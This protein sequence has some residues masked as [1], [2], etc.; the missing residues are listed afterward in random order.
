LASGFACYLGGAIYSLID[1]GRAT[2]RYL[3]RKSESQF[4]WVPTFA[5]GRNGSSRTG[6]SAWTRF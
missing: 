4:G 5:P 2:D 3:N 6:V 1:T